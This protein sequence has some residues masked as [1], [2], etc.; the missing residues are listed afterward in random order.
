MTGG[1]GVSGAGTRAAETVP[2]LRAPSSMLTVIRQTSEK[3]WQTIIRA[4]E[5]RLKSVSHQT[6]FP[7]RP[8]V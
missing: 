3:T 4:E 7:L 2:G 1:S 8:A 6:Q 5:E